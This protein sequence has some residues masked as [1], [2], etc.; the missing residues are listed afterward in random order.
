MEYTFTVEI[1][2]VCWHQ[3]RKTP[4]VSQVSHMSQMSQMSQQQRLE[5][6]DMQDQ[7]S[8][9][10]VGSRAVIHEVPKDRVNESVGDWS[11]LT[12]D[13]NCKADNVSINSL[14][15][16]AELSDSDERESVVESHLDDAPD[17]EAEAETEAEAS[18]QNFMCVARSSPD[19]WKWSN[20]RPSYLICQRMPNP[21]PSCWASIIIASSVAMLQM[22]TMT[23]QLQ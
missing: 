10:C 17:S 7:L 11:Q 9:N 21:N 20:K 19:F 13:E 6:E 4:N 16:G 2:E 8:L 22:L 15:V 18:D 12:P 1:Q 23:T 5:E 3:Q 14:N